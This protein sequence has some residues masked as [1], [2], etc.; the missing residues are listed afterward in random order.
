MN[1][2]FVSHPSNMLE[3]YF[4]DKALAALR[5]FADVKLNAEPHLAA[6]G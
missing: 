4:G 1:S 2:V 5:A 6:T 3:R